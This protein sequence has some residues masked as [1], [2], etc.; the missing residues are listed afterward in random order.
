MIVTAATLGNP[1]GHGLSIRLR[2]VNYVLLF[3]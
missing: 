3:L 1:A 2:P